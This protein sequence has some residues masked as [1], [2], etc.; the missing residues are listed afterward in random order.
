M[1]VKAAG[2]GLWDAW[3]RSGKSVIPQPLPLTLGSDLSGVVELPGPAVEQLEVGEEIFGVT[4]ERFTGAYAEYALAKASMIARKPKSL[5]Y[6]HAASV[7]VA[8]VTA[9]Q[10]VFEFARLASGKTV[11]IHGGA[12][13]VAG[14]RRRRVRRSRRDGSHRGG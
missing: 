8:A 4:N 5:N 2:V 14:S 12:G 6:T 10:M 13:N 11:L 9:W 7:P 1:R 3:I